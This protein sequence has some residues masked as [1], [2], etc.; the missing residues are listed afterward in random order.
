MSTTRLRFLQKSL[1]LSTSAIGIDLAS[2]AEAA[3]SSRSVGTTGG[4]QHWNGTLST[5]SHAGKGEHVLDAG[6][7]AELFHH[8]GKGCLTHM[9]FGGAFPNYHKTVVRVYVDGE[10]NASIQMQL[11]LGH[12]FGFGDDSAPWGEVKLGKTGSQSGIYNTYRIPYGTEIRITA[13]R[14][15]DS[16]ADTQFWW[17]ARCTDNL[18]LSV[19]GVILPER[20]RL[21]L[22]KVEDHFAAP[23]DEITM[24]NVEGAGALYQVTIQAEAQPPSGTSPSETFMEGCIRAYLN[25]STAPELLSSGYEDYFLGTYYFNRGKY[26]T[27]ISGLTHKDEA[28]AQVSAYRFHDEDPIFFQHGMRLTC[29]CGDTEH[30]TLQGQPY[31]N[32]QPTR[33]TT[34]AWV[35]HL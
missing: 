32:P 18:P 4:M 13:Q 30:A 28:T 9:W 12:G 23:L 1:A 25:G 34:Y 19:G 24:C 14:S 16:P 21:K 11:G 2:S 8:R 5:F 10:Q 31:L 3:A 20:A 7:E 6:G 22:H 15:A 27:D 26:A 17:I 33:F 35:Y 29:R